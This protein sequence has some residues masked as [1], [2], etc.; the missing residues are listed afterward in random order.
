MCPKF[1]ELISLAHSIRKMHFSQ[2]CEGMSYMELVAIN[3]L[4]RLKSEDENSVSVAKIAEKI[5]VSVPAVS[6]TLRNLEG[7]SLIIRET[8]KNCRRNTCVRITDKGMDLFR[9]NTIKIQDFIDRVMSHFTEEE[10]N[11]MIR[12]KKKLAE[13]SEEEYRKV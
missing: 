10:I 2:I 1:E 7:K 13:S 9:K 11:T 12:L 8:D 3:S 4:L 6:R 5:G